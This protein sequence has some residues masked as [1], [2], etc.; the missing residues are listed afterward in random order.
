[1]SWNGT[2]WKEEDVRKFL[3]LAFQI[4]LESPDPSTQNG[5]VIYHPLIE[6]H[7]TGCNTF[8]FNVKITPERLERPTKMHYIEHAERNAVY[9]AARLGRFTTGATMFCPWYSCSDCARAVVQAGISKVIGYK[10]MLDATPERW[11]ES[12]NTGIEIMKEG[13]VAC[14][15][16]DKPLDGVKPIRFNGELWS[17]SLEKSL[18]DIQS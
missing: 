12:V 4:A 3:K 1:M 5:A 14:Y 6:W 9:T 17:P 10:P 13:G 15:W 8:P 18:L 2:E 7:S 16:Y 11:L